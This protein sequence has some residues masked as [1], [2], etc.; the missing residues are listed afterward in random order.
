MCLALSLPA[1]HAQLTLEVCKEKARE[2]YPEIRRY[3]LVAQTR[4]YTVS[5]AAKGYLPQIAATARVQ[6]QSDATRFNGEIPGIDFTGLPRDQYDFSISVTQPVYDGGAVAAAKNI[7]RRQGE[8]DTEQVNVSMYAIYERVEEMFFG[9]LVLD[10]QIRQVL[11]LQDDLAVSYNNV[12]SMM[13]GGLA[14]ETDVDAVRVEQV[15][16]QQNEVG[17]RA[18]RHAYA[19]MLGTFMGEAITDGTTLV[20]P[21]VEETLT[22]TN[23]RP[24]LNLYAAQNQLLDERRRALTAD[25]LPHL[26]VFAEGGYGNPALNMFKTGFHLYYVVGATLSWNIGS[27]YTRSNDKHKIEVEQQTIDSERATF[28]LNTRL[29]SQRQDGEIDKLRQQIAQDDEIIALRENIRSKAEKKVENGTET[30]NE[31]LRDINA[32]SDAHQQKALHE[33]QLVQE[34]YHLKTINNN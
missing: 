22:V 27:L 34:I 7:A 2:N 26:S 8:V 28:L 25:L 10:E 15:S 21:A 11:L 12:V 18:A 32:V 19:V 6:Y 31:M 3:D 17:L 13:N 4:D 16:A 20:L 9:I 30:V 33:I 24:E 1:A 29:Q 14:N 5:N 23:M